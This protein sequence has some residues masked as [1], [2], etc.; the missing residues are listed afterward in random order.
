MD[1]MKRLVITVSIKIVMTMST[2]RR[3]FYFTY[4]NN[5]TQTDA[6]NFS[7]GIVTNSYHIFRAICIFFIVILLSP[8]II[9]NSVDVTVYLIRLIK[10]AISVILFKIF[11]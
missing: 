1:L 4:P 7:Y 5:F 11:H 3:S 6:V 10:Y 9:I 8:F 2:H